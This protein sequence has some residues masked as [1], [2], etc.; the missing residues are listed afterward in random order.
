MAKGFWSGP[1]HPEALKRWSQGLPAE[2]VHV[3]TTPPSGSSPD[4]L[5][6]R[7]MTVIGLDG[8]TYQVDV[9]AVNTSMGIVEAEVL[10]RLNQRHAQDIGPVAYRKIFRA[11]LFDV[12]SDVVEDKVKI[13]LAPDEHNALVA[14]G[15]QVADGIQRA[16]FD[17]V[18]SL[19]ELVP[20]PMAGRRRGGDGATP[21]RRRQDRGRRD[22]AR[23]G[24]RPPGGEEGRPREAARAR[25][26]RTQ[27]ATMHGGRAA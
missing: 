10:R 5:W 23:R 16:G 25:R 13:V 18:G 20:E 8:P 7:F 6:D 11:G 26:R 27:N 19:N 12:L 14:R 15:K 4:V 21:R 2:R 17:V 24:Q 3:V 1:G 9:P 22:P